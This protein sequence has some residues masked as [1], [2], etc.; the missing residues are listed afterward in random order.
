MY[1][2]IFIIIIIIESKVR[3]IYIYIPI[4]IIIHSRIPVG[5][6]PKLLAKLGERDQE[7]DRDVGDVDGW[8]NSNQIQTNFRLTPL[9]SPFSHSKVPTRSIYIYLKKN[10]EL[11]L[12]M[13]I[14]YINNYGCITSLYNLNSHFVT[15]FKLNLLA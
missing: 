15:S 3:N 11:I 9:F 13:L 6:P 14:I 12:Y 1:M 10:A 4:C 7:N 5:R 8:T 2:Y